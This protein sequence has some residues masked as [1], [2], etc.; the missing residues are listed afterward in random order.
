VASE[1]FTSIRAFLNAMLRGFF[2]AVGLLLACVSP[3]GATLVYQRTGV[4]EIVAARDD[5]SHS[6]V[7]AHG[8][9]PI[10]SP[11]GRWVAFAKRRRVDADLRL[12]SIEG[13]QSRL[14]RHD[15]PACAC[16]PPIAQLKPVW[17]P[18]SRYLVALDA[19]DGVA[20]LFDVARKSDRELTSGYGSGGFSPDASR[21]AVGYSDGSSSF[22][23]LAIYNIEHRQ[24]R[25]IGPGDAPV[26]GRQ[27]LAFVRPAGL[28]FEEQ[29]GGRARLLVPRK[30]RGFIYP[31]DW[32]ADGEKLLAAVG[33]DE[34][35]LKALLITPNS[36][37]TVTLAPTFSEVDALSKHGTWV[38][39]VAGN[40]VLAVKA[41]GT[42]R[43]LAQNAVSAS[44]TK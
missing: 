1:T 17:S 37:A 29:I 5:G 43:V 33:S 26:W 15:F 23:Q 21:V 38:L 34:F 7:I 22:S 19:S 6:H 8:I 32:S 28:V 18:D 20:H 2:L 39:G 16:G 36:G 24:F 11:S 31:V 30:G 3:A 13:G 9:N 10:V 4:R 41:D 27:G 44:W 12:V 25:Q 14:L 42:T 40:N 35:A